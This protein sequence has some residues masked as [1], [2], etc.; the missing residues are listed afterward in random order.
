MDIEKVKELVKLIEGSGLAE[1]DFKEGSNRVRLRRDRKP[2]A[3]P[4][5]GRSLATI[6]VADGTGRAKTRR[7]VHHGA[8]GGRVLPQG[9]GDFGSVC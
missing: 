4:P 9:L 1:I 2:A 5:G 8:D 7:H 3:A 6:R